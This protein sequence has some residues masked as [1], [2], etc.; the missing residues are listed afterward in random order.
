MEA[1]KAALPY[2][3]PRLGSIEN[4]IVD[5][6]DT[7]TDEQVEAWLDEHAEARLARRTGGVAA[8]NSASRQYGGATAR[9]H[10]DAR[11]TTAQGKPH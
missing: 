6:C 9:R 4:K 5:E 7:M 11:R 2:E 10:R 1:A 3:K 8:E